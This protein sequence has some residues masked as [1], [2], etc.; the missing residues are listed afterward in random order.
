MLSNAASNA[1]SSLGFA[2]KSTRRKMKAMTFVHAHM[3]VAAAI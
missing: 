1:I 3:Y 2:R